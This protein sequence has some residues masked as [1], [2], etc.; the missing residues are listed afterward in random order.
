MPHVISGILHGDIKPDNLAM[1]RGPKANEVFLL[2][3]GLARYYRDAMTLIHHPPEYGAGKVG[4]YRFCS[5]RA[6]SADVAPS[7][8]DDLE[9]LSYLL[10]L[11][12]KGA[13]QLPP[14]LTQGR[15]PWRWV[16]PIHAAVTPTP[17][18]HWIYSC[19]MGRVGTHATGTLPWH[20]MWNERKDQPKYAKMSEGEFIATVKRKT[21]MEVLCAGLPKEFADF[22]M[23]AR[24][25]DFDEKPNYDGYRKMFR[26]LFDECVCSPLPLLALILHHG[27][28]SFHT[29]AQAQVHVPEAQANGSDVLAPEAQA[30]GAQTRPSTATPNGATAPAHMHG[31]LFLRA[32]AY[33]QAR[34]WTR[35]SGEGSAWVGVSR[36]RERPVAVPG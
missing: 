8:R 4:N 27:S 19:E 2:D 17:S 10:I 6:H 12:I 31:V 25:L 13:G 28:V 14:S 15:F 35:A 26:K 24:N 3:F 7:R 29:A 34:S 32:G 20:R 5:L 23:S 21:P 36:A 33:P 22:V 9:S 18:P 1:G 16:S 30:N 11:L